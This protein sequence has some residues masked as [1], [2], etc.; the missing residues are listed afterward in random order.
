MDHSENTNENGSHQ[1]NRRQFLKGAVAMTGAAV[2]GSM[3]GCAREGN[4]ESRSKVIE[5]SEHSQMGGAGRPVLPKW[6]IGPFTRYEDPA[7]IPYEGNPLIQPQG[8]WQGDNPGWESRAT[9]NPGVVYHDGKFQMLYRGSSLKEAQIG[10]A[11][12]TDGYHFTRYSG[13]PVIPFAS[14]D[15]RLYRFN[16]KYYAFIATKTHNYSEIVASSD[17]MIR[18][19]KLATAI[20][21]KR[22]GFDAAVVSDPYG[23]PVKIN[24]RYIMYYGSSGKPDN[25]DYMAFSDDL[26][27]WMDWAPLDLHFPE[28]YKPFEV[29]VTLTDYPTIQ[30]GSL[31]KNILMFV[32]GTLM[33]QGRWYYA[34]SE[35][36]FSREKP[37]KQ[38]SQL[39]YPVLKPERPYE[40]Y[41][42]ANRTIW[43]NNILFHNGEWWLYYGAG[44]QVVALA[45]ASLRSKES[46]KVYNDFKGT[47]FERHQR[48]PD[49]VHGIDRSQED[50]GIKNVG[51]I[52]GLKLEGPQAIVKYGY[53]PDLGSG[54]YNQTTAASAKIFVRKSH[55]GSASLLYSGSAKG[56]SQNYIHFKI[57]DLESAPVTVGQDMQLAYWIYPEDSNTYPEI[58]GENSKHVIL[59]LIFTDGTALRDLGATDQN[60]KPLTPSGQGRALKVN[61]W[62]HV[63]SDIGVVAANKKIARIDIA[64][65]QPNASGSF[66]G[67]FDDIVLLKT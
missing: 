61:E 37:H 62:N 55:L 64:Y 27:H 12:S 56:R 16:G 33:S 1:W 38:I 40:I 60:D 9:F 2:T 63:R 41:G 58:T 5:A 15:P 48:M 8:R 51:A 23:N 14:A 57:F 3:L 26:V 47:S 25:L 21:H 67:Y 46:A 42:M 53:A 36:L 10:Y 49:W 31:N 44:D 7:K 34:I 45:K 59:D 17:D 54:K 29:C 20:P 66:R 11:Y 32:G 4:T 65:N 6:A 52:E 19:K 28:S 39:T 22:M 13:N 35:V 30:G 43:M 18:W 50:E 24:G